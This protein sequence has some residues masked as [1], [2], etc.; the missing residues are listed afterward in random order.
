MSTGVE[1]APWPRARGHPDRS[2]ALEPVRRRRCTKRPF[3]AQEGLIAA[4]GPLV[5]RTGQHTGRSPNDKFI[6]REPSSEANIAW[7]KV[8]RPMEPAQFDALHRDL[9]ALAAGQGAVRPRLLRRRRSRRTACRSASST[10]TPG[11]TCSA[12]TCSSTIR[13]RPPAHAPQFT[14]ID[15]PSFKADPARHGTRLRGRHRAELREE[16]RADRRHQLRRRD[17]EVDLQ[18]AELPAAAAG[19][20]ARCTARPTSARP[21][22][23]RCSSACRAPARRRCRAIPSA[24]LI[25]DDEHGWSDRGVFNFEGGCYAKTIRLSAEAEP[26]IYATTRRFGTVLE[27]VVVDPET[28]ALDLDDDRYTENT[29]AAYPIDV[30]RQRRA[31][32]AGRP[33]EERRHADR[34][35]VRRAAADLAADARRRDVSLPVRLHREGRRHREGRDRAEGDLQHLLRRAVPAARRRAVYAQMLGERIAQHQARVWLVNTGWTGGPYGVGTRMKIALHA[36]DDP[37]GAV[38]RAR[39]RRA[40]RRDPVFNLDVPTSVSRRAG[41]RARS[42]ATPGPTRRDYDAQ[43][44]EAGADVRRELQ[45]ASKRTSTPTVQ[46]RPG[47]NALSQC[48]HARARCRSKPSSASRSTRSC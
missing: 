21:A 3:A 11:T 40:T 38:R 46:A 30:H 26:Q 41:R 2:R 9:L 37:R 25:G 8:N 27:N 39:R 18:R 48:R 13:R 17:Q 35:R 1:R 20:A 7:G 29:R 15:A 4:D 36:R 23:S 44:D 45:D 43:A 42:R 5:C 10:S 34:R 24:A 33:S 19:R 12:A 28:R 16:A 22:T 14:V 32:R 47:P 31:V 6:V